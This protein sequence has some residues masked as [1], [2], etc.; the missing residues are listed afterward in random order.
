MKLEQSPRQRIGSIDKGLKG[1]QLNENFFKNAKDSDVIKVDE[2]RS[3]LVDNE[4]VSKE[5]S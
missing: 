1:K 5:F 4:I 3:C 2:N